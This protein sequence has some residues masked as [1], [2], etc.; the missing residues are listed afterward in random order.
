MYPPGLSLVFTTSRDAVKKLR[1]EVEMIH[2]LQSEREPRATHRV[3]SRELSGVDYK[4][5]LGVTFTILDPSDR[6][7]MLKENGLSLEFAEKDFEDRVFGPSKNP[8][9]AI[10]YDTTGVLK[11]YL[12]EDGKFSYTYSE[13][14]HYQLPKIIALLREYPDT[15]QA[16]LSIWDPQIDSSRLE[17]R[18]VPCSIGYHFFLRYNELHML[19]LMRSLCVNKNL[20]YDI[21]TASRLLDY[22][23]KELGVR[24]RFLQFW[25]GSLHIFR[26]EEEED[27]SPSVEG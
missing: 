23:A 8:G 27:G 25:A 14:M 24:P 11:P 4:E 9:E 1:E 20:G 5:I 18:R 16:F 2:K 26:E 3:N 6:E 15:R 7:F 13:R 17:K 19:Y 21:Y 12:E 10:K 22:V